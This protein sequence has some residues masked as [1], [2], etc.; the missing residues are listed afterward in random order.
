MNLDSLLAFVP[1]QHQAEV[2]AAIVWWEALPWFAKHISIMFVGAAAYVGVL[3]AWQNIRTDW[4]AYKIRRGLEF[5]LYGPSAELERAASVP[6]LNGLMGSLWRARQAYDYGDD[7]E[8]PQC[9]WAGYTL[10][11]PHLIKLQA[12]GKYPTPPIATMRALGVLN[13]T[14]AREAWRRREALLA[15]LTRLSPK[16]ASKARAV[17]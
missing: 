9:G 17:L 16:L 5:W 13:D 10:A 12:L 15:W 8:F 2:L 3:V 1:P 4:C 14:R 6:E 7:H 11:A